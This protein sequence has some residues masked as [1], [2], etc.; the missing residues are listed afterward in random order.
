ML[1]RVSPSESPPNFSRTASAS[2]NATTASPTTPPAGT[3]HT[4]VRCL[5]ASAALPSRGPPW[6]A[7]AARSRT[8]SS[9]LAA[10]SA[11]PWTCR[12][13]CRPRGR[14]CGRSGPPASTISSWAFDPGP[15]PREP[16]PHLDALHGLDP[17]EPRARAARRACG[18]SARRSRAPAAR[19]TRAPRTPRPRVSFAVGSGRSRR[20]SPAARLVHASNGRGV[21]RVQVRQAPARPRP[22]PS[23]S[24]SAPRGRARRS[25]APRGT[26]CRTPRRRPARPSP[27]RSRAPGR[28]ARRRTRTSARPRD[29]RGPAAGGS[30]ARR[31][32]R[33]LDRHQL[34]VLRIELHVRDRDR[35]RRAEALPVADAAS[36]SRTGRPRSAAGPRGRSRAGGAPA[37]RRSPSGRCPRP[38]GALRGSRPAPSRGTRRP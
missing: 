15:P 7:A 12:P 20:P 23:R 33:A 32:H 26:P 31:V 8:A 16:V 1:R 36:G 27:A 22:A 9:P 14:S 24:R 11:G 18:R 3:A 37:P 19:R 10:G 2:S 13:R 5:I 38:P 25:R 35:H 29:P 21:D 6:R 17:H 4:S 34:G 28:C 30:A